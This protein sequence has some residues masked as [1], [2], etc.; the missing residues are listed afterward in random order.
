MFLKYCRAWAVY[1]FIFC[2][3]LEGNTAYAAD[4]LAIS[5][6]MPEERGVSEAGEA[7]GGLFMAD[8]N[9]RLS[10]AE[11]YESFAGMM[12]YIGGVGFTVGVLVAVFA[13]RNKSWRRWGVRVAVIFSMGAFVLYIALALMHDLY[14]LGLDASIA[15]EPA[16]MDIYEAIYY[17]SL[18]R[19]E[20]E[21][22][23]FIYG[24][25]SEDAA[26]YERGMD[27]SR[28]LYGSIYVSLAFVSVQIGLLLAFISKGDRA[29]RAWSAIGLC[30]VVPAA[31]IIGQ[32]YIL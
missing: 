17:Q 32:H 30:V 3:A 13:I 15:E 25:D 23:H 26:W 11:I 24:C 29:L 8:G 4:S 20:S 6:L 27:A 1:I 5:G 2:A 19:L 22:L 9:A 10:T 21:G 28:S 18:E 12:P 16:E 7:L 14:S 31:L